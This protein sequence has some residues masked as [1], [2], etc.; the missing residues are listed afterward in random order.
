MEG[1]HCI[2]PLTKAHWLFHYS[3]KSYESR[4]CFSHRHR[5]D[6]QAHLLQT[7][8]VKWLSWYC[9]VQLQFL[10]SKHLQVNL[11]QPLYLVHVL[12]RAWDVGVDKHQ[13][14]NRSSFHSLVQ[15][16]QRAC[17][18]W[19]FVTVAI[20]A[21]S[22]DGAM[23]TPPDKQQPNVR[24]VIH[25]ENKT[26]HKNIIPLQDI[27]VAVLLLKIKRN[28]KIANAISLMLDIRNKQPT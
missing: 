23:T 21:P 9:D 11:R 18:W 4:L 3:T 1:S 2:H 17:F 8:S 22:C 14:G 28:M 16:T 5:T 20:V 24:N 26:S 10:S 15:N 19:P 6:C 7:H 12:H 25:S 27:T 13:H